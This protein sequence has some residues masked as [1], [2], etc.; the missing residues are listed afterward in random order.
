MVK[1]GDIGIDFAQG[2]EIHKPEPLLPAVP[3]EL[4]SVSR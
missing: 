3:V 2:Y 4:I 1:L